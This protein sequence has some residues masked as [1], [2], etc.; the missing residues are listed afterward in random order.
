MRLG[1]AWGLM[2]I[3][4]RMPSALNGISSSLIMSPIVPFCPHLL[5]NL[6]PITGI[7]SSR[8][9]TLA[10]LEPSAPS[11]IKV[12]STYPSC[13]F[14]GKTDESTDSS[15][16]AALVFTFPIKTFFSLINVFSLISPDSSRSE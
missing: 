15:G 5:Q 6:S 1:S 11:V 12:L 8:T 16:L 3:S 7:L 4:G 13:P 10:I 2:M 9:R 14:L